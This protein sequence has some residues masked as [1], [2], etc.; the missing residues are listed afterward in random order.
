MYI[1]R[2]GDMLGRGTQGRSSHC[3]CR[4][5]RSVRGLQGCSRYCKVL[6]SYCIVF[7]R[8]QRGMTVIVGGEA[9]PARGIQLIIYKNM[10]KIIEKFFSHEH[11]VT[12]T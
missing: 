7:S 10:V 12:K 6:R 11:Q 9:A 1:N 4:H 2:G 5:S 8:Q 3:M